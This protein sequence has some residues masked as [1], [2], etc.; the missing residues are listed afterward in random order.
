M[1]VVGRV[2]GDVCAVGRVGGDVC[3]GKGRRGCVLWEG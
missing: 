2:G 3:C 1:C